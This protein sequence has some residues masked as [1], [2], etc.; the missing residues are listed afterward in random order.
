MEKLKSN[1]V[2]PLSFTNLGKQDVTTPGNQDSDAEVQNGGKHLDWSQAKVNGGPVS[3][4]K[5][6]GGV[7]TGLSDNRGEVKNGN[8]HQQ[9]VVPP[10]GPVRQ[11]SR[12]GSGTSSARK[13]AWERAEERFQEQERAMV[14]HKKT[15]PV[16]IVSN[17]NEEEELF[18]LDVGCCNK[19][20]V[21]RVFKSKKFKNP[22]LEQLYQ[23]YF[24]KLNQTNLSW[25]MAL[26]GT[27]CIVLVI[28]HYA[29]GS[30]SIV[31]GIVLGIIFLGFVA[32]EVISNQS[33]FN[34]LQLFIVSYI[35]FALVVVIV[36]VVTTDTK[37]RTASE[38]VWCTT[39]CIYMVYTLLP[40]RMRL[41]VFAG[42][43]LALTHIS[44]AAA[45]NSEDPLLWQQVRALFHCDFLCLTKLN[46]G[47]LLASI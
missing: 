7:H 41:S 46:F 24:F 43:V 39:F 31:K 11:L 20:A 12:P 38:G 44:C 42:L 3:E 16:E 29:G 23:R 5:V 40:V 19:K 15:Q 26:L 22:K 28:F 14:E 17:N 4:M 35:V 25:L 37:P 1:S 30:S 8:A 2:A 10:I 34:H 9:T 47:E 32:L 21:R 18:M 33:N 36:I 13:S 45:V 6:N 27:L